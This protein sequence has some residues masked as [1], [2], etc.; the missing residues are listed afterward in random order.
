MH[1]DTVGYIVAKEKIH[2]W[3]RVFDLEVPTRQKTKKHRWPTALS[4]C[5]I[6]AESPLTGICKCLDM[7]LFFITL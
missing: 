6:P 5:L 3:G 7:Q 2:L 1:F 4:R